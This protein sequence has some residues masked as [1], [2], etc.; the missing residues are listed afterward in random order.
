[1]LKALLNWRDA[2]EELCLPLASPRRQQQADEKQTM[3]V[4]TIG[5]IWN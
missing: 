4:L 1:M 2:G 3:V 5:W